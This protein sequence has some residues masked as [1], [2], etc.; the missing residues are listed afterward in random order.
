VKDKFE[1]DLQNSIENYGRTG[2]EKMTHIDRLQK[3]VGFRIFLIIIAEEFNNHNSNNKHKACGN[4][5]E[6][7]QCRVFI[8]HLHIL[9][10]IFFY[11][12]TA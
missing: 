8:W 3:Q 1:E 12:F 5:S 6:I 10:E 9:Y 7:Q 11:K 2:K 4:K